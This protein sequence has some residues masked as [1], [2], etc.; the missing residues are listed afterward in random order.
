MFPFLSIESKANI[1]SENAFLSSFNQIFKTGTI[2][3][4]QGETLDFKNCIFLITYQ[5]NN[6]RIGFNDE[7][8]ISSGFDKY[9]KI[10]SEVIELPNTSEINLERILV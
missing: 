7:V 4:N 3:N 8:S 9:K 10:V 1:R 2:I 6:K 5:T